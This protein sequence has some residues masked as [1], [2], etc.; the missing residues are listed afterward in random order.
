MHTESYLWAASGVCAHAAIQSRRSPAGMPSRSPPTRQGRCSSDPPAI[1]NWRGLAPREL[2]WCGGCRRVCL[3]QRDEP[4]PIHMQNLLGS[5]VRR[6]ARAVRPSRC[7]PG[8]PCTCPAREH[9]RSRRPTGPISTKPKVPTV[10]RAGAG[11]AAGVRVI[12]R[13]THSGHVALHQDVDKRPRPVRLDRRRSVRSHAPRAH[14][15][16]PS[17]GGVDG[18]MRAPR[19]PGRDRSD[20]A[21]DTH[22]TV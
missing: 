22:G 20:L 6:A 12:P 4:R 14:G 13:Y 18:G 19:G 1:S 8:M 15:A 7:L 21:A 9:R 10:H 11:C 5:P 17:D 3:Q 2:P 16:P